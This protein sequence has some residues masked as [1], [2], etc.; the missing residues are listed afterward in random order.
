[1]FFVLPYILYM[2]LNIICSKSLFFS[3]Y[4]PYIYVSSKL[5]KKSR[6]IHNIMAFEPNDI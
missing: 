6:T 5:W 1:M 4:V 2:C 3:I